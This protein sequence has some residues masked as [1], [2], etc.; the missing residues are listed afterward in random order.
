MDREAWC[1]AVH[2]VAKSR[3]WLSDWTELIQVKTNLKATVYIPQLGCPMF[4]SF[5]SRDGGAWWAAIYGVARV[6]HDWSDLA[7]TAAASDVALERLTILV[8]LFT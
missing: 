2:G 5:S 6:G 7:A 8:M 1:A 3:T 4:L